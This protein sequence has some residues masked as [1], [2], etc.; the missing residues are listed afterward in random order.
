MAPLDV[1][2]AQIIFDNLV[3]EHT[4][5]FPYGA[6][7]THI[8]K[9]FKVDL[10]LESNVIKTFEIFDRFVLLKIKLLDPPPQPS[11]QPP[12]KTQPKST[13]QFSTSHFDDAYYNTLTAQIMDIKTQ[14]A[15]MLE[16]QTALLKTKDLSWI[17]LPQCKF[18]WIICLK[19]NKKSSEFYRD[20][21]HNLHHPDPTCDVK[22]GVKHDV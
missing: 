18:K 8:F 7:L 21:F 4:T 22:R 2:L 15:S 3:K 5:F 17:S 13:S 9:K 20:N 12:P 14:Q 16:S 1:N 11:T 10:S 19:T 6:Y